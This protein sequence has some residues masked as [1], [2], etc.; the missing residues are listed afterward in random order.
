MDSTIE[1]IDNALRDGTVSADA[2]RWTPDPPRQRPDRPD[3]GEWRNDAAQQAAARLWLAGFSYAVIEAVLGALSNM[4]VTTSYYVPTMRE[5]MRG[6]DRL[7]A[8]H[9]RQQIKVRWVMCRETYDALAAQ[10]SDTRY[11][12]M[13]S[14]SPFDPSDPGAVDVTTRTVVERRWNEPG[15]LFGIPIRLEPAARAPIFEII[16]DD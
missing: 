14:V 13:A 9:L 5:L 3:T 10:Y 11:A 16:E 1:A 8:A 4:L 12:V 15:Y 2:M 7:G 6:Y